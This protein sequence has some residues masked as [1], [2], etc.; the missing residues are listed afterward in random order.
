MAQE[1]VLDA[2]FAKL[3]RDLTFVMGCF[4]QVLVEQGRPELAARLPWVGNPSP[5]AR[6]FAE[7]DL[8]AVSLAFQL[9]NM[10]EENTENQSRRQRE[11]TLGASAEAGLWGAALTSL[12]AAGFT[13]EQIADA[14]P[15]IRVEPVLTAHPT[16]AKRTTVIEAYRHLYVL[17]VSRENQ[18]WTPAEQDGI[19]DQIT[20]LIERL[21]RTGEIR[22]R[23]P[24]VASE[25]R[26]VL[27]YLR[28]IF[29]EVVQRLDARLQRA[30][31]AVGFAA[32]TLGERRPRLSFGTWVGGD[33]DGHPLVTAQVTQESLGDLRKTA[34]GVLQAHLRQLARDLSLSV[35]RQ[36]P[37]PEL[38]AHLQAV[39]QRLGVPGTHALDRNPM[40]PWRQAVNLMVIRLPDAA[41]SSDHPHRYRHPGEL[42]G[43]LDLLARSL[44]AI[45]ARRLVE[46][47]VRPLRRLVET[48]GF[49]G[50]V[51]DIRQNSTVHEKA[52]AQL[53]VAAGLD[54]GGWSQWSEKERL[55]LIDSELR[56]P[57]PL[58]HADARCGAESDMVLDCLRTVA[59][60]RRQHGL[61]GIGALIVSM[62]RSL[63]DLLAVYVLSRE[64]GL[65]RWIADGLPA[66]IAAGLACELPVVPLFETIDDLRGAP[67]ILDA[68]LRHPVVRRSLFLHGGARPTQQ[69]MLGYSDSCKDGGIL[70]SQWNLH[71]AQEALAA[72]GRAHGVNLR[73]F[74]GR[75][76]TVS[77][78]AGPTH[79]F[80]EALPHGSLC[81]DLRLTEQGETVGQKYGNLLTGTYHLELLLA[82]ATST[83]L[84]HRQ[85]HAGREDL[86]PVVDAVALATRTA[87]EALIAD[88]GFLA[89]F[90]DATPIDALEQASIGSRPSRR[91][92][93]RTLADLRA[94]PWVF[95]WNQSRH[96][97]P[98]WFGVGSGLEQVER[99][100]PA[101]FA[102]F[103]EAVRTWPFLRYA[104]SNI[105]QNVVSADL[106]IAA[107][108]AA[109]VPDAALRQRMFGRIGDEHRRTQAMLER[110][111]GAALAKRRPR[112]AK[113]LALRDAGLRAMHATQ[114]HLLRRWRSLRAAGDE[115]AATAM[116]PHLLLTVNAIA[117]GLRTTG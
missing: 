7:G 109:M 22:L 54:A 71:Q 15:G 33:R 117:S 84:R 97:L 21:W 18:M 23:K 38:T 113:T 95:S 90:S 43:D 100:D 114:I 36:S 35:L 4:Q 16:E 58:S 93:R 26:A 82:G 11:S 8:Q 108:Y 47:G 104:L 66:D 115:A 55:A 112:L 52:L 83:A 14:L 79:R 81:G 37:P 48:Y 44:T 12:G 53:L 111:L 13:A 75:G 73:F 45:G 6:E 65:V 20:A 61:D 80:L 99:Q 105:E 67:A 101:G 59:A 56:S 86:H 72:V 102:R 34:L 103:A 116:L 76:G 68:Y 5:Q 87:Y 107:D 32:A 39:S 42:L 98:G 51:L 10:V 69:V 88:D 92:G 40:E 9:L 57:R 46:Q 89:Y 24:D 1:P 74:H 31:S 91:T 50:A 29:P 41:G 63:S 27:H 17:L 70:A 30:W 49:H 110:L 28:D 19:R 60:H 96:F 85:E 64:A 106:G 77:R 94:I 3:E 78:G 62:T 2:A 25:R